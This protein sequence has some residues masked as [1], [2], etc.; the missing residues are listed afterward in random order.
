MK[1]T[2]TPF[3]PQTGELLP[4]YRDAYLRGD[5]SDE[6]TEEV[7]DYLRRRPA[8]GT[9]TL[10]RFNQMHQTGH[11]VKPIG[12]VQRQFELVKAQPKR[13]RQRATA[14][15]VVGMMISGM[16]MASS[17]LPTK[18]KSLIVTGTP[19]ATEASALEMAASTAAS[20]TYTV[21]GRILNEDGKPLVGATII[22]RTTGRGVSTD[23]EGTYRLRMPQG[24]AAKLQYAYAG[25]QDEEL[26]LNKAGEVSLTL[27]PTYGKA[28]HTSRLKRW[29]NQAVARR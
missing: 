23:A 1:I 18:S 26:N 16:V 13:I 21:S 2:A 27:V 3:H 20:A 5:L 12:W 29:W 9:A 7:D 15:A 24:K 19:I 14:V 28:A 6:R 11:Q 4:V 10:E 22:D 25:Y 8:M 17:G